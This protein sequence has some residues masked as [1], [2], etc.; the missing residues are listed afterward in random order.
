MPQDKKKLDS[1]Q[2]AELSESNLSEVSGGAVEVDHVSSQGVTWFKVTN[3]KTGKVIKTNSKRRAE[4]LY[5][6]PNDISW[7]I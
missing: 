1:N 3:E 2:A 5:S 6:N 7:R 4:E